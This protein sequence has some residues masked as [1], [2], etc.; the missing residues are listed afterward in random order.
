MRRVLLIK[1]KRIGDLLLL[2]PAIAAL[3][4]TAQ[5]I[6]VEV[7]VYD[8][9]AAILD[10]FT[11]IDRVWTLTGDGIEQRLREN[12][13]LQIDF[14]DVVELSGQP[15]AG[16]LIADCWPDARKFHSRFYGHY[17]NMLSMVERYSK[18]ASKHKWKNEHAMVRDWHVVGGAL[19]M[20]LAEP[21]LEYP[22][23]AAQVPVPGMPTAKRFAV[24]QP[25]SKELDRTWPR[26]NWRILV[27]ELLDRNL[28]DEIAIPFGS[29]KEE[30]DA[31]WIAN[32]LPRCAV[33]P[34]KLSF[35]QHAALLR[36]AS[37][38]ISCNT[39]VM[40]LAAAVGTPLVAVW[41]ATPIKVW[42]PL[43]PVFKIVCQDRIVDAA[44]ARDGMH[45]PQQC[46]IGSNRV[47]TVCSAFA[48][49]A[50]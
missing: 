37:F 6:R 31:K 40:H 22:L 3:K 34:V 38:C 9:S 45:A 33:P 11:C 2:T 49:I 41:G 23:G 43:S 5:D 8:K 48:Q 44:M 17:G 46:E 10:G 14:D 47:E 42:H 50:N 20:D 18:L 19:R 24:L 21:K 39:G 30:L 1:P 13:L 7:L 36:R 15:Y 12:E 27:T 25:F 4:T 32:G 26:E 28:I 29:D 16:E 35:A